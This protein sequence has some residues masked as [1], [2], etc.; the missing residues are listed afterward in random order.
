VA[1]EWAGFADEWLEAAIRQYENASIKTPRALHAF[2]WMVSGHWKLI[3][4]RIA[5][6]RNV[7]AP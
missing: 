5:E 7:G 2:E 6:M 4:Q 3:R 1:G